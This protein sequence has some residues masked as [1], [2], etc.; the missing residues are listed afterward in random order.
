MPR[1]KKNNS[2]QQDLKKSLNSANKKYEN[3]DYYGALK[4]YNE[5]YK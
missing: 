2:R 3:G 1:L 5:L 4:I